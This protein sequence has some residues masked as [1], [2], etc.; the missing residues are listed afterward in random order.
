AAPDAAAGLSGPLGGACGGDPARVAALAR[1]G[2]PGRGGGGPRN[3]AAP[4]GPAPAAGGARGGQSVFSRR[5]GVAC[6]GTRLLP[7]ARAAARDGAR[8]RGGAPG[9]T[10]RRGEDPPPDGRGDRLG[11]ARAAA[12]GPDRAARG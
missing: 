9:P 10:T 5:V 1:G 7:H 3:G 6:G 4:G 12:A 11:G 2:Q 8:S